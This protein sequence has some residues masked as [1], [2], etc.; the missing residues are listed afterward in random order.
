MIKLKFRPVTWADAGPLYVWRT[1]PDTA[2]HSFTPVPT[3]DNHLRWLSQELL[4][5]HVYIGETKLGMPVCMVAVSDSAEVS[6]MVHPGLRCQ[7]FAR[8]AIA[9]L[10]EDHSTLFAKVLV[11]NTAGL[12]LFAAC[13]FNIVAAEL[14]FVLLEWKA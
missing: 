8:Q 6:I 4:D 12:K 9:W 2:R 10:Q 3:W 13:D 7:G 5:N 11:G 14:D 1:D